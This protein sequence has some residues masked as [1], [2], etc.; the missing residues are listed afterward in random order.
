[1]AHAAKNKK[2]ASRPTGMTFATLAGKSGYT[3]GV[4]TDAGIVD[5]AKA[6]ALFRMRAP[7]TIDEVLAGADCA[8]LRKL[9]EKTLADKRGRAAI[10]SEARAKFGPAIPHP[11]KIICVG[12]NYRGHA[13]ETGNQIPTA[14]MLFSKFNNALAGH[15]SKVKLPV[16]VDHTFDYEVELVVV[17]GRKAVDVAEDKALNYVFGYATGNDLSARA[18][19]KVTSQ[20]ML[21]K[22][23]DGFAPVGPYVVTADQIPDPQTLRVTTH[24]N[25]ELRQNNNTNDMIFTCAQ[26]VSYCSRYMTLTPGDIIYTGTPQGVILGRPV[27]QRVW[28]KAGDRVV[29][30]VEK[31]GALEVT[32]V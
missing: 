2:Y 32:L 15:R 19:Q 14:P 18:L 1:M 22:I 27:E 4:K 5:V 21:G 17:I 26:I 12:L 25:G 10:V 9:V 29:T 3:L 20:I 8:P 7:L 24:V 31:L 23:A 30:E 11:P 13:A 6:A 28:L 16:K